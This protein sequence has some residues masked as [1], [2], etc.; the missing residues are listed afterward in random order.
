MDEF[1]VYQQPP[2][3]CG[4]GHSSTQSRGVHLPSRVSSDVTFD[5]TIPS[6]LTWGRERGIESKDRTGERGIE[7]RGKKKSRKKRVRDGERGRE[8]GVKH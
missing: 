3:C 1:Q 5:P 6:E 8:G 4:N 2:C 7:R